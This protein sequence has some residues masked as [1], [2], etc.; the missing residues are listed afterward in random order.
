M[1]AHSGTP[2][3]PDQLRPL[4]RPAAAGARPSS[5]VPIE[6]IEGKRHYPVERVQDRWQLND[7]WW[8]NPIERHYFEL[9]MA[10][11][12]HPDRLPRRPAGRWFEQRG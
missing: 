5:G 11:W 10:R 7:E 2:I 9:V 8:R 3:R 12:P 1:V 4:N 6:I